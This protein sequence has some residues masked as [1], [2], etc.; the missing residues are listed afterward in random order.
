LSTQRKLS[1]GV[2][3]VANV[4]DRSTIKTHRPRNPLGEGARLHDEL[5]AA[6]GRL[7]AAGG[8]PESLTLRAVAREAGIAA[9][10]V[11]LQFE[12]KDALLRAVVVANFAHFQRAIEV[13]VAS[14]DDAMT[15]LRNGCLAYCR[16]AAEQPGSYRVIFETSLPSWSDLAAAELPGMAAFQLLVDA[17]AACIKAGVARPADPFQVATDIWVALHGMATLRQRLPGFPWPDLETQLERILRALIG[18]DDGDASQIGAS[19]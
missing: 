11:Y 14:G 6:A 7:L 12:N 15:R 16:Y 13:G 18:H 5:I 9:P 19:Q 10:S 1:R 4:R 17:V 8:N 3:G 2:N